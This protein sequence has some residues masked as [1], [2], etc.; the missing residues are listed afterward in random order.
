MKWGEK[1]RHHSL[2]VKALQKHAR[3]ASDAATVIAVYL[4]LRP[5]QDVSC[6]LKLFVVGEE[7]GKVFG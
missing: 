7:T 3:V 4:G 6:R 1:K 5:H 2:C